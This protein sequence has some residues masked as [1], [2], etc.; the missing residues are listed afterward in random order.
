MCGL[1][2][3]T[4]MVRDV[5]A[6]WQ[7]AGAQEAAHGVFRVYQGCANFYAPCRLAQRG[8]DDPRTGTRPLEYSWQVC[9]T[10]RV[11]E[12]CDT[13]SCELMLSALL[14]RGRTQPLTWIVL[15]IWRTVWVKNTSVMW[16]FVIIT[17]APSSPPFLT[18]DHERHSYSGWN[19]G[20]LYHYLVRTFKV[21]ECHWGYLQTCKQSTVWFESETC[22][23]FVDARDGL[24]INNRIDS[25]VL[26]LIEN[27]SWSCASWG[28]AH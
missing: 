28:T 9:N 14:H 15:M 13:N 4:L 8:L 24:S 20:R 19:L 25:Q 21:K 6:L 17:L 2:T 5:H 3:G 16:I 26:F 10:K 22:R 1:G 7:F 23:S 27:R 12:V 18:T 11:K